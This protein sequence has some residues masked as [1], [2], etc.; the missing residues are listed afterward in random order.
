[1]IRALDASWSL[2]GDSLSLERTFECD[3]GY[4]EAQK[5][6][7]T[8]TNLFRN[9]NHYGAVTV[10]RELGRAEW[11]DIV[12]VVMRTEVLGGLSSRDF[13]VAMGIDVEVK[14]QK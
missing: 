3:G 1:M 10:R 7:A 4:E 11:M 5:L 13:E 6:A 12:E 2:G 9:E 14:R 8:V